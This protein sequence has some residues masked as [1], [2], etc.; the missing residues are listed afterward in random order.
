ML[1]EMSVCVRMYE[2]ENNGS[3]TSSRKVYVV[4]GHYDRQK[5]DQFHWYCV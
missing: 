1:Q 5:M 2:E 4:T 3:V